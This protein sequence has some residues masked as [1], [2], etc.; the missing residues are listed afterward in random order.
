MTITHGARRL[1][2]WLE[3]EGHNQEWLAARLTELRGERVYQSTVSSWLRG[4]QVPLWGAL[5][6]QKLTTIEPEAWLPPPTDSTIAVSG[7]SPEAG[8]ARAAS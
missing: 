7:G 2:D 5:A 6:L 1:R 8:E 3:R 4:S